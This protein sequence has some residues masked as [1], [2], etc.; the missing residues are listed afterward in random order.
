VADFGIAL[1]VADTDGNKLTQ[2]GI[3]L[4]TPVYM[5]PEQGVGDAVGPSSDLYSLGCVLFEM[6]VGEPPFSGPSHRAILARH[7][8]EQVPSMRVVRDTIPPHVEEAV[9]RCLNKL[10]ADRP[11]SAA[12]LAAELAG[13]VRATAGLRDVAVPSGTGPATASRWPSWWT[14]AR[15]GVIAAGILGVVVVALG[16]RWALARAGAERSARPG[17]TAPRIAVLYFD[18]AGDDG[19]LDYVAAGLTNGVI[20][21][22]GRVQGLSVISVGGVAPYRGTTIPRDSIARALRATNLVTGLVETEGDSIRTTVRL[23]DDMAVELDRASFRWPARDVSSLADNTVDSVARLIRRTLGRSVQLVRTRAGTRSTEAWALYQRAD[24]LRVRADSLFLAD[25]ATWTDGY[26]AADSL[27]RLAEARDPAW[28]EPSILRGRLA[29]QR[30]RRAFNASTEDPVAPMDT[31]LIHADRAF[32]RDPEHPDALEL[33]GT[34][35]YWR[36]L[37]GASPDSGTLAAAR[38]DLEQATAR[39]PAQAGAW[40]TLSHLYN[41]VADATSADIEYAARKALEADM[42]LDNANVI[43]HR[44]FLAAFDD[45]RMADADRWCLQGAERFPRDSR[46]AYCQLL[47]M[48]AG[49]GTPDAARAWQLAESMVQLTPAQ[50]ERAFRRAQS[51]VLV[52]V[53][54]AL[55]GHADSARALLSEPVSA[56]VDPSRDIDIPAQRGWLLLGDSAKALASLEQ[57]RK[58]NPRLGDLCTAEPTHW[59]CG[60]RR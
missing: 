35:R 19:A 54:M 22:L 46:F 58:A 20:A 47:L 11:P 8:M 40:A 4:G 43:V 16:T 50:G 42:Y 25:A 52:G 24:L 44:L 23:L 31:G 53:V 48:S 17:S 29:Y 49:A 59:S 60:F 5:S 57:Y 51:R 10:P 14:P 38:A 39:N 21:V 32:G 15:T 34:L 36:W 45:D 18:D 2:T 28:A 6:L 26:R 30:S 1:A 12:V 41:N 27:A 3:S 55:L 9:R 33:R 37:V 7:A 56:E 13:A